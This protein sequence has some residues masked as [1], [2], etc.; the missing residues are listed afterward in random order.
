MKSAATILFFI[1]RTKLLKNGDAP[2]FVRVTINQERA[3]FG[4]KKSINPSYWNESS[5]RV[6]EKAPS[7]YEINNLIN[8][9]ETRIKSIVDFLSL[10][11][12]DLTSKL[13]I[14]KLLGKKEKQFTIL[15]IFQDHNNNAK[16]LRNIDFAAGTIQRYE[17]SY[18]HTR[19][20]IKWQ[21][22]KDDLPL[23]ELN[24]QFIKQYELYLKTI[25]SCSHNTTIK[26]LKNFKKIVRIALANNWLK[27]DPFA[28]IKYK[29]KQVD[30]IYLTVEE[31]Q[32]IIDK[33]FPIIRTA[34]VKDVF[35]FCCFTGLAFSDVKTLKKEHFSIDKEGIMWIHKKRRKTDQMSTIYIIDAARVILKKYSDCPDLLL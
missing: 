24:Q 23:N 9:Y 32:K 12:C 20:F 6:T 14:E 2:I 5:Q 13:V 26:Y 1:K 3:E 4:L 18:M 19:D 34:Q 11:N 31:L 15:Q 33:E 35:L 8:Q 10:D 16:K 17:T 7:S 30:T 28:T 22:H 21:Y 27:N 25:R 29:L